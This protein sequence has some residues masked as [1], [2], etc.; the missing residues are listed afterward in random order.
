MGVGPSYLKLS[1][2]KETC[3][4]LEVFVSSA[5]KKEKYVTCTWKDNYS[6]RPSLGSFLTIEGE[7]ALINLPYKVE[8]DDQ[9]IIT[10]EFMN[11]TTASDSGCDC[12]ILEITRRI[13][14]GGEFGKTCF[15]QPGEKAAF[16]FA[17]AFVFL[18][19]ACIVVLFII[20]RECCKNTRLYKLLI[21]GNTGQSP[22]IQMTMNSE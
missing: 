18:L 17:I 22:A 21:N 14:T 9:K 12:K 1:F 7:S 10:C 5:G 4:D 13:D 16:G 20:R 8:K 11:K 19:I 3:G 2:P 6:C 15:E